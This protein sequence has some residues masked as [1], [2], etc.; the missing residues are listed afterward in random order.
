VRNIEQE[1][2]VKKNNK[3]T[4]A[5]SWAEDRLKSIL[6]QDENIIFEAKGR[7]EFKPSSGIKA[8]FFWIKYIFVNVIC[9]VLTLKVNKTGWLVITNKRFI[10]LTNEGHNWPFWVVP[11]SRSNVDYSL[12]K[13]NIASVGVNN[14]FTFWFIKSK[15]VRLETNGGFTLNFNGMSKTKVEKAKEYLSSY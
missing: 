11:Y 1:I 4:Q 9:L 6:E 3:T 10:V 8:L 13:K 5:P 2:M 15:G 14:K 12:T 7:V